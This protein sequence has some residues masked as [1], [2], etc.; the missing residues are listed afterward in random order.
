MLYGTRSTWA[1]RFG[2]SRPSGPSPG[3]CT[4]VPLSERA[5]EILRGQAEVREGRFVF[6]GGRRGQPLSN[7]AMLALLKRAEWHDRLVPHGLRSVFRGWAADH[8]WPREVAEAAL[9][10][11]VDD[12][13]ERSY[14][15]GDLLD[16][17]RPM[18]Q[19]WSE[20]LS[21]VQVIK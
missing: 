3:G 16:R 6:P 12:Q 14:A 21:S 2:S 7:A 5:I 15:R 10:H 8:S 9:G 1:P 18:M 13:V 20:Y 11:A 19:S 4:E 17:R